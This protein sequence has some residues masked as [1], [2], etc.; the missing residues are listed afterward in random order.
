MAFFAGVVAICADAA[1]F[2]LGARQGLMRWLLRF[3]GLVRNLR[4]AGFDF[5]LDELQQ[6]HFADARGRFETLL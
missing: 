1:G 6:F 4:F 5:F 3:G 2:A